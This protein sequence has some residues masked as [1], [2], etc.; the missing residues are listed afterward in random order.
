MF[1]LIAGTL[2]TVVPGRLLQSAA[3]LSA[4]PVPDSS[5]APPFAQVEP[6]PQGASSKGVQMRAGDV[7]SNG[8][9]GVLSAQPSCSARVTLCSLGQCQLL[10]LVEHQHPGPPGVALDMG[11]KPNESLLPRR[12]NEDGACQVCSPVGWSCLHALPGL[13]AQVRTAAR[14][15]AMLQLQGL[16]TAGVRR[17][18]SIRPHL[19]PG[20]G[21]RLLPALLLTLLATLLLGNLD[22]DWPDRPLLQAAAACSPR[23]GPPQPLTADCQPVREESCR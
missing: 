4:C 18:G 6:R 11:Q 13:R 10:H 2:P 22:R 21:R 20:R 1:F 5:T 7:D 3:A 14:V 19:L 17:P 12:G 9:P 8:L 16:V 23:A 15:G